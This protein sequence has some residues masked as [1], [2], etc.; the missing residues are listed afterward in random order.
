MSKE[1]TW[2]KVKEM[3][4]RNH[5]GLTYDNT[6]KDMK[7]ALSENTKKSVALRQIDAYMELYDKKSDRYKQLQITKQKVE[8][9]MD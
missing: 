8:E 3:D 2:N 5:L 4:P 7:Q 6:E 1:S 9:R